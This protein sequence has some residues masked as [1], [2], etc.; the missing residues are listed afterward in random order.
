MM[1]HARPNRGQDNVMQPL[2]SS[3]ARHQNL[4]DSLQRGVGEGR[5]TV[6]AQVPGVF[7]ERAKEERALAV[8]EWRRPN[9]ARGRPVEWR[10][11]GSASS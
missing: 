4:L 8:R 11:S 7:S 5:D 9:K 10:L 3:A 2:R 6:W 1:N